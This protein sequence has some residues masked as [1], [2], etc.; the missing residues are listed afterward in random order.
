MR[1]A[2]SGAARLLRATGLRGDDISVE[3]PPAAVTA[4]G[5]RSL[6]SGYFVNPIAEGADPFVIRENGRYL[7]SQTDGDRG[8]AVASSDRLTSLGD[9]RVVWRAPDKGPYSRQV[10]APE[11]HRLDG[12][13]YIYFAASDGHND[14]HRAYVL[15]TD[16]DDP[17]GPYTVHG[18]M[19]TGNAIG[20][21]E[22]AIDMTVLEHGGRRHAIWSGWP[23]RRTHVQHLYIAPLSSP[24]TLG[25]LRVMI[26]S[27]FDYEWERVRDDSDI[28]LNE[29]PQVLA[30]DGRTFVVFSCGHA[31][32]P[33]Y[34]LGLL[35]LIADDPLDPNAWRKHPEPMFTGTAVTFGVGHGV[36]V[37]S[38]DGEQWW[39]AY[40]A[41]INRQ[42][43]FKRVVRVQPMRWAA[44]GMP[45]F[46]AP[47]DAGVPLPVPAGT[48]LR[49]SGA[50]Q[51]WQLDD[52]RDFD[53]FGHQQLVLWSP[54]GLHLGQVPNEPINMFRSAEKVVARD[55]DYAD[56]RATTTVCVVDGQ[57]AAGVLLRVTAP[58]VGVHAQRGYFAGWQTLGRLLLART[59]GSGTRILGTRDVTGVGTGEQTLVAEA[60]GDLLSVYLAEAPEQRLEVRDDHYS[61]GS[62]GLRVVGTTQALFTQLEATAL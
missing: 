11:L 35:E 42:S 22:W 43:N 62:V 58:A 8:I 33:S 15:V 21:S 39:L 17:F 56:V 24:T 29:A 45:E 2:R 14:E 28:G 13:W 34:K 59:D 6:P 3:P 54:D 61:R 44:D 23:D 30:R 51:R 49:L 12:R 25:A 5:S 4:D 47:I 40:H 57:R 38:S 41:K 55:R 16:A 9:R 52:G 1:R 32:R 37:P 18:P 48:P 50:S 20:A 26:S 10:W 7:W 19:E 60:R 53:Y 36:C 31:L 27:P 46:G